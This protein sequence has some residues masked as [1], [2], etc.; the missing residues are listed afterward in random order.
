[1]NIVFLGSGAFA[2]PS[3]SALA[4]SPH[5]ILHI[6]SQP[7]RPAGRGKHLTPTPVA[8]WALDRRLPLLRTDNANAEALPL[9][10]SLKPDALVVIAFGQKLSNDL[11][12]VAPKGN[13]NL[14][15]SLLPKYRG[16]A[17]INWAVLN[18]D[19]I[20]GVCVIEVTEKMDAGDLFASASTPIGTSETAGELHD[21]LA[22]L[23]SPLLPHVLDQLA[24][25]TASRTPQSPALATR[26][27][28][29]SREIAWID[30]SQPAPAVS[31]RIRGMSPWPGIQVELFDAHGKSRIT[32]T[33]LKCRVSHDSTSHPPEKCGTVLSDRSIACGVG[34]IELLQVQPA[35]KKAMDIQAFAN[36][37][38]LGPGAK[39]ISLVSGASFKRT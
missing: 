6:I 38:G 14:H 34:S 39:L 27:P 37:Y 15:S 19:P 28:K 18:N 5:K 25:G 22:E 11:L 24:A 9:L 35:G 36:G 12:A 13:I 30:F 32:A 2:I 10:Q 29:L 33:L 1:M 8:Q 7:D 4:Q 31:A 26:A 17:P 3:L 20:A 21:R 23:G 16:A